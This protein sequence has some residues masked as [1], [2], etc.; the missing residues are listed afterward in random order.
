MDKKRLLEL[1]GIQ[2]N[3]ATPVKGRQISNM[4]WAKPKKETAR[5]AAKKS[6]MHIIIVAQNRINKDQNWNDLV[7]EVQKEINALVS[8]ELSDYNE[9]RLKSGANERMSKK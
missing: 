7:K 6:A 4:K 5:S 3:E 2:L 1:A 8:A 9:K